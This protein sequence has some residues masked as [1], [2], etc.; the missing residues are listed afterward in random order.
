MAPTPA[1]G[2]GC[3]GL[4]M[5]SGC[6]RDQTQACETGARTLRD[7]AVGVVP[8]ISALPSAMPRPGPGGLAPSN[9]HHAGMPE[10]T[11]SKKAGPFMRS[12]R[13]GDG[14]V[15][16]AVRGMWLIRPISPKQSAGPAVL[17]SRSSPPTL[18]VHFHG[19]RRAM[20]ADKVVRDIT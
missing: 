19:A 14:A 9:N 10:D 3:T 7:A 8:G 13:P 4:T 18:H 6:V 12:E 20:Q 16:V 2:G 1:G 11:A 5:T 17:T 15:T